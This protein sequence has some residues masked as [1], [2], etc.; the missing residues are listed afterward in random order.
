MHKILARMP[1]QAARNAAGNRQDKYINIAIDIRAV[2][3]RLAIGRKERIR[4]LSYIR[5]Q[6]PGIPAILT[7]Q[8]NIAGIN[9]RNVLI[10]NCRLAEQAGIGSIW[11]GMCCNGKQQCS[12]QNKVRA[13]E[14]AGL[15]EG[16]ALVFALTHNHD[17]RTPSPTGHPK[18]RQTNSWRVHANI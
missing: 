9:K 16:K 5:S 1:G 11:Y 13:G 18:A 3:N 4:F 6:A 10:G 8:P 17:I 7:G 14:Q 12:G 15:L 2:G